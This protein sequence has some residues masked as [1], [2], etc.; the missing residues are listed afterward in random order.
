MWVDVRDSYVAISLI[1]LPRVN[2]KKSTLVTSLVRV[3]DSRMVNVA[4][5]KQQNFLHVSQI[6]EDKNI[7][8]DRVGIF[9][10]E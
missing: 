8:G 10:F 4:G 9:L 1:L 5:R 7:V 6:Q 3:E 2:I